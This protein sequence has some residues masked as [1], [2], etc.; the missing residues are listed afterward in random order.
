[1]L[2]ILDYGSGNIKAFYNIYNQLDIEI[3]VV[4]N[5]NELSKATK[6]ILP[7]VG[8]FDSAINSL[9]QSGL[10]PKLEQLVLKNRVPVLGV[11]VGLQMMLEG[12]E[13]GSCDGLGWIKGKVMK[14]SQKRGFEE[15]SE[16]NY[17]SE[18]SL[19]RRSP[20]LPHMGWNKVK[21]IGNNELIPNKKDLTFYFLHSYYV[22]PFEK[23]YS[24]AETE[25]D[26]LFCSALCKDN[27]FGVQFHPEKSHSNGKVLLQN[28]A[29]LKC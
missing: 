11:C 6:I 26:G 2:C 28:Y 7:G 19:P 12:S 24:I 15:E 14:F 5:S 20:Q 25:Y 23:N 13:E 18:K 4:S 10:R 8:S 21:K 27:I 3:S 22:E 9:N 17:F 29:E 1:M 16:N